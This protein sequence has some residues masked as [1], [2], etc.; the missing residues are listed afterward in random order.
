MTRKECH[1][2]TRE[3]ALRQMDAFMR[4]LLL[5]AKSKTCFNGDSG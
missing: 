5:K 4:P 3:E 1:S 2:W